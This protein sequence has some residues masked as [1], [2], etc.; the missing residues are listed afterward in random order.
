MSAL[1]SA[2]SSAA[3]QSRVMRRPGSFPEDR[4]RPGHRHGRAIRPVGGQRV[5]DVGGRDDPAFPDRSRSP[6]EAAGIALAVQPLVMRAG[7]LGRGRRTR[8]CVTGWPPT[9]AAWRRIAPTRS[10]SS[11]PGLS[12][13][14]LLTPSLPMSCSSAARL[15]QR[16]ARVELHL[17]GDQIG[18]DG[19][20]FAVAAGVRALGVDDPREGLRRCRRDSRRRATCCLLPGFQAKHDLPRCRGCDSM[21]Q[22]ASVGATAL[23]RRDAALR[24][25]PAPRAIARFRRRRP[26]VRS[27]T[28][29][30]STTWASRAMRAQQRDVAP[31]LPSGLPP[32]SQC[33]SR[34]WMPPATASE[35]ASAGRSRRRAGSASR[36]VRARSARRSAGC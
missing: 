24:I 7:D 30:T 21:S 9:C 8:R 29:K 4:Q 32:P 6:D 25:E 34:S 2:R 27:P 33:S 13:I 20:A 19:D 15:S 31:R 17:L 3:M 26:R 23:E 11:L 1:V 5:E 36:S 12:R 14:A 16:R 18:E 35:N 28:W 22:N 10:S